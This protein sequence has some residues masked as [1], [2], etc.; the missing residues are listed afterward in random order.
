MLNYLHCPCR[1]QPVRSDFALI[2]ITY[3]FLAIP[4][5]FRCQSLR[6][7]ST[8]LFPI[9]IPRQIIGVCWLMAKRP[10]YSRCK[11]QY[12]H[13]LPCLAFLILSLSDDILELIMLGMY[14]QYYSVLLLKAFFF[15]I[16]ELENP[17]IPPH[18]NYNNP[19][20]TTIQS[21]S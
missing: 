13:L 10:V 5:V 20:F 4:K 6:M 15:Y 7:P 17:S 9:E 1:R 11:G 14:V 2:T 21:Q 12:S 3:F 18:H 16:R 19:L 8:C